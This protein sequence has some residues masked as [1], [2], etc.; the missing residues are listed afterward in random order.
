MSL[1]KEDVEH[2]AALARLHVTEAE[3]AEL[4]VELSR[5]LDHATQLQ[6]LD[7]TGVEATSHIGVDQTVTRKDVCRPSLPV[8]AVL[9][10]APDVLDQQFKVPAIL[11]G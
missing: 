6:Q 11:E 8:D 2:V 3:K 9:A 1:S 4:A 5:I 10:N 7:L